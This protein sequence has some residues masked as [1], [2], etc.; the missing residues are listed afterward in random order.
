M[1]II[2]TETKTSSS[3]IRSCASN[4]MLKYDKT[5]YWLSSLLLALFH[6]SCQKS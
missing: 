5:E 2:P 1:K 4:L 3:P 6:N